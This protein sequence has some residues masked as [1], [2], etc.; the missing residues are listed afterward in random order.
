MQND[1]KPDMV[2]FSNVDSRNGNVPRVQLWMLFVSMVVFAGSSFLFMMAARVPAISNGI[3]D[4]LGLPR[5]AATE[6]VDRST[7][8][9]MLLFCY[10]SPLMLLLWVS[11]LQK[12]VSRRRRVR[13]V[14]DNQEL[15][16]PFGDEK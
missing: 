2:P 5:T 15:V 7:H 12:F 8:L 4:L 16:S 13:V 10:T 9:F 6:K 14:C 3:N 11:V 1:P